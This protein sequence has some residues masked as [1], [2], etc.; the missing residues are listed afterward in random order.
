MRHGGYDRLP[1]VVALFNFVPCISY[2]YTEIN[3][4]Y[5]IYPIAKKKNLTVPKV[6]SYLRKEP[7]RKR[8]MKAKNN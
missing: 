2:R 3:P 7:E 6:Y 8:S 1:R 5:C 4:T